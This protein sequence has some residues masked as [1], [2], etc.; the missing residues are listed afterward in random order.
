M[1]NKDM[2]DLG[3]ALHFP[4]I[5]QVTDFEAQLGLRSSCKVMQLN[6]TMDKMRNK[7]ENIFPRLEKSKYTY[8]DNRT[9]YLKL[10]LSQKTHNIWS[11]QE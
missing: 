5:F 3:Q 2:M 4:S 1:K 8:G 9:E 10:R 6:F 7:Q 11:L